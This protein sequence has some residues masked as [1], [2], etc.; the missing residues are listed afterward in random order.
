MGFGTLFIGYFLILNL[1]YYS[2]TDV[3]AASVML[4]GLYKLSSVN[5]YFGISAIT[6]AIFLVFS[7]GELGIGIYS[8]FVKALANPLL[9]SLMSTARCII[10]A[11]LTVTFL[12]GIETVAKE[13]DI[14]ELAEKARRMIIITAVVYAMWIF[15]EAPFAINNYVLSVLAFITILATITLTIINLTVIYSCYMKICMPGDEDI[16]KDK[17]SRFE[18]VN[19]YRARKAERDKEAAEKRLAMLKARNEKRTGKKK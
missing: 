8:M 2:F 11:L 13:V 16:M 9:I 1:T 15:L 5:K 12:K 6:S 10:V 19:E 17:P 7:L 18:F 3:I 4:L 14:K